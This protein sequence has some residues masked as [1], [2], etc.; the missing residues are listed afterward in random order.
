MAIK[1]VFFQNGRFSTSASPYDSKIG[2]KSAS[3]G[4]EVH[5][6]YLRMPGVTTSTTFC[7]FT[8]KPV[9]SCGFGSLQLTPIK[10]LVDKGC[11]QC[12]KVV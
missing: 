8:S 9:R 10:L 2:L 6:C 5:N 1:G 7:G 3:G 12:C 11:C 4:F